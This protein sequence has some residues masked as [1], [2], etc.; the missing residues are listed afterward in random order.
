MALESVFQPGFQPSGGRTYE[1]ITAIYGRLLAA[2]LLVVL[3]LFW[4]AIA[5]AIKLTSAGPVLFRARVVGLNGRIFEYYK[6]RT[7][8]SGSDNN[9]HARW[10]EAFVRSD[11]PYTRDSE[12]LP[13]YKVVDDPRVTRVGGWLRRFSLDEIP[14][15]LN[16]LRGDMNIIGPR[17][18]VLYEYDLYGPNEQ[19]RLGVRPGITGLCQVQMRSRASFSEMLRL[20]LEYIRSR[21]LWLD[22]KILLKTPWVMLAGKVVA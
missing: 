15:L 18:P 2:G 5:L 12:G 19:R 8:Y 3:S 9:E 4:I 11:R 6:F 21:S 10:I 16:V 1:I 17:P 7:M 22:L 14:Q 13:V 20:D